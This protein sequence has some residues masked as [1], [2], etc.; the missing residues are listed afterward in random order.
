MQT[1]CIKLKKRISSEWPISLDTL[2]L[3]GAHP[4]MDP[5]SM[6]VIFDEWIDYELN[7]DTVGEELLVG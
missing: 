5:K 2:S 3:N 1:S 7:L 6:A 4:A